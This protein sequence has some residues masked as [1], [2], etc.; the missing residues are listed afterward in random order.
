MYCRVHQA[1]A[2]LAAQ[3]ALFDRVDEV[4]VSWLLM[5]TAWLVCVGV[6]AWVWLEVLGCGWG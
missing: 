2:P 1:G 4:C 5:E 6:G 3:L